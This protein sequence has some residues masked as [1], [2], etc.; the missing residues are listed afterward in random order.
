MEVKP[1]SICA[2][3]KIVFDNLDKTIKPRFMRAKY[4]TKSLHLVHSFAMKNRIDFSEFSDEMPTKVNT[5]D[6]FQVKL[7]SST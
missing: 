5:L 1:L 3:Y 2:C 4:Q 7:I 6:I